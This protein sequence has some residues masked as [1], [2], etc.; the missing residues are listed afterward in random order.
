M[1]DVIERNEG[2]RDAGGIQVEQH[3]GMPVDILF[4]EERKAL[5]KERSRR[6]GDG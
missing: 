2:I 4:G 6:H 3:E 1:I 5:E